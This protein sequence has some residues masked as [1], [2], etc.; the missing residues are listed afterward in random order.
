M[1]MPM[2]N[3]MLRQT[4][5]TA[6]RAEV[7]SAAE[8]LKVGKEP[9]RAQEGM[10]RPRG[11][12]VAV[13]E[14]GGDAVAGRESG[15]GMQAGPIRLGLAQPMTLR[16]VARLTSFGLVRTRSRVGE[17]EQRLTFLFPVF[18]EPGGGLVDVEPVVPE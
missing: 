11:L 18:S 2:W 12:R 3:P 14:K 5:A 15:R 4:P 13:V 9:R 1:L 7:S 17:E 10:A 16:T 6:S 8:Q